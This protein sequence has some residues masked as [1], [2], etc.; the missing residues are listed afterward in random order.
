MLLKIMNTTLYMCNSV[1]KKKETEK[2][3]RRPETN[4]DFF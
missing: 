4:N 1:R 2:K 3:T